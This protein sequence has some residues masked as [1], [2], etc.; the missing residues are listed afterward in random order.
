MTLDFKKLIV[1]LVKKQMAIQHYE[2]NVQ[3]FRKNEMPAWVVDQIKEKF[4]ENYTEDSD[5]WVWLSSTELSK[6]NRETV[7]K[8]LNAALGNAA[9]NMTDT[10][11]KLVTLEKPA[12]AD[13][14]PAGNDEAPGEEPDADIDESVE[15][16][17]EGEKFMF[18][19]VTM[20]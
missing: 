18:L 1:N 10:D 6:D 5:V 2:A 20:K 12:G 4:G 9:N 8:V 13:D 7:F 15:S 11:L 17:E 3:V 14:E 19:K 16:P